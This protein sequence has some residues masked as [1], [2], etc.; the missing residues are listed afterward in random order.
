M[1]FQDQLVHEFAPYGQ[2]SATQ[3]AQLEAHYNLLVRWN[4]KLNLT[5]ISSMEAAIQLHYCESLFAGLSL[6]SEA[7]KIADIG[8]GA[9]FPGLP[10]AILRPECH[11]TLVESHQRKAVFLRE[12]SRDLPNV[13]VFS[14]R[15]EDLKKS[16]DW[17]VSRA[18]TPADV[19]KLKSASRFLLLI[20][21]ED[22]AKLGGGTKMPWGPNRFLVTVQN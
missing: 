20:G 11:L 2:L 7:L 13:D 12:A 19:L 18:V 10:I 8:T 17:I 3:L 6:P 14:G 9:G 22:T 5:R 21:A 16:F 4:A 15:A 1:A